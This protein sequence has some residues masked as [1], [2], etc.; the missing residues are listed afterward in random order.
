MNA[1]GE[2]TNA[3]GASHDAL[4]THVMNLARS[5][6]EVE[7]LQTLLLPAERVTAVHEAG[8]A[9]LYG[10][11]SNPPSRVRIWPHRAGQRY[12][13]TCDFPPDAPALYIDP[14]Q[15]PHQALALASVI[16]A[17][18]AAEWRFERDG[19]RL[20]CSLDEWVAAGGLVQGAA[21]ALRWDPEALLASCIGTTLDRLQCECTTVAAVQRRLIRASRVRGSQ[22]AALLQP[23]WPRNGAARVIDRLPR[24]TP[25]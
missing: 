8:H 22:R 23:V 17:G 6:V 13:D 4:A 14:L 7:G 10:A 21:R 12:A 1:W 2:R 24:E 25:P 19:F 18:W 20:G 16:L 15:Q 9:V 3:H 11:Q 5:T